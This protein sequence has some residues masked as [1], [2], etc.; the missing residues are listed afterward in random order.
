MWA[1]ADKVN[2]FSNS[3]LHDTPFSLIA[4]ISGTAQYEANDP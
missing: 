4:E 1:F 3:I 2:A